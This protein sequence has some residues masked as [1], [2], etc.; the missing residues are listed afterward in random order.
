MTFR[1]KPVVKRAHRPAWEAQDRRNFYLNLGFGLIVVLAV[2]ILAIAAGLSWYNEHLAPV[3]SVDG[4]SITKDDFRA[5]ARVEAWRLDEAESRVSTAVLAGHL[6]EAEGNAQKQ[7]IDQ[8][9]QQLTSLALERIIDTRLQATLAA[10]E[11]VTA[12]PQDVDAQLTVEATIP[13]SR[14]TWMI[15]VKP[16]VNNLAALAPTE[17]QKAAAKAK[18]ESALKDI[19][20]GK[21]WDDVAKTVS[22]DASTA[23]Q[24]GDLG[25][26]QAK[27][28]RL[29]EAFLKAAFAAE[30]NTPTGVVEGTDGIF[31]IGRVTEIT[32]S[33]VDTAYEAKIVNKDIS[34]ESYRAVVLGDVIH[35]KLQTKIVAAVT[36]TGPQRRVSEIFVGEPTTEPAPGAVKVRHILF[37]PNGDPSNASKVAPDDPAWGVASALAMETYQRLKADSTVFD[38]IARRDSDEGAAQGPTGSGGKLP[39][40]DSTSPADEAFKAAILLPS[41]KPGDIL[42]PVKSAFGWHVIQIMYRPTDAAQ[43]EAL[44]K[45]AD[46]GDDFALLA[47]DNS[48]APTSGIGGDL[49]W[50]AKGQLDDALTNA[51][52]ATPIGKVSAVVSVPN[53]GTY[54]FK[55]LAEETRTPEG[56]QLEELKSTAFSKW[57]DGKKSAATITRDPS[58]TNSTS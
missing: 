47:R 20:G 15:E 51:I 9:R 10:Q 16:V 1:A 7:A 18:A 11:G 2:L 5:R 29:D 43:L 39:Y 24:A 50:V 58:F 38:A 30:V 31:R 4:S 44:K 28:T 26:L 45:Q 27:D 54:L 25:W 48:E 37:S 40:I 42:T 53:D 34:L 52:F 56:R 8:Q 49:G 12:T 46:K 13:E 21:S 55:V 36:A 57:Y 41:L 23:P 3:G 35:E 14:H 22:T 17:A 19:Q 32:A 6:T 33:S